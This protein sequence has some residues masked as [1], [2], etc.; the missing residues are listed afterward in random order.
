[1]PISPELVTQFEGVLAR[2][3]RVL[4]TTHMSP[5]GDAFGSALAM[6]IFLDRRGIDHEVLNHDDRVPYNLRF[7]PGVERIRQT[8]K[9]E[10]ADTAIVLDLDSLRRVGDDIRALV[11]HCPTMVLID[12]HIPH[13]APGDLRIV[14]VTSPATALILYELFKSM[15][16]TITPEM[17]TC[18]LAGIITDT[19]GFRYNNTTVAALAASAELF[20]AG[21]ALV[22]VSQESYMKK[23]L[24]ST[25]LLGR[26]L[27][28]MRLAEQNQLAWTVLDSADFEAFGALEEHSEGIANELLS[29]DTVQI[30]AVLRHPPGRKMRAS[31]RSRAK[32]DVA[33][34]ARLFQGG[35]H[36]NAAG[37]TFES[38]IQ[39]AETELV[40]E[41][42]KCLESS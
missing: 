40:H 25:K 9:G 39:E 17:A 34:V 32:Y 3:R 38:S 11:D 33:A 15:G 28:N 6:S 19:G 31:L 13:E 20:A 5:D 41:L 36:K 12:H 16:A 27:E 29:I 4:V 7:L 8:I 24:E 14:D 10:E 1:M 18:L 30:A 35:G 21:G 42:K 26:G 2:A 23:P 37:C 22:Q